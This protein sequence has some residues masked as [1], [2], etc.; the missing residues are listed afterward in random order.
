MKSYLPQSP[1]PDIIETERCLLRP[2]C[3]DDAEPLYRLNSDPDVMKYTGDVYFESVEQS[4]YFLRKYSDYHD[5]ATGRLMAIHKETGHILGW[6]GLKNYQGEVDIGYRFF[7]EEWG[8]G[9]ATETSLPCIAYG[10][11]VMKLDRIIAHVLI[12]NDGSNNVAKKL[13]LTLFKTDDYDDI[14]MTNYYEIEK[15]T[16]ENDK[17]RYMA[18]AT[19]LETM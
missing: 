13:G 10:F 3:L 18:G 15:S 9:Y 2:F 14:G 8:K 6:S 5:H 16:Y 1:G 19:I 17:E 7:K 4:E 12:E 11:E